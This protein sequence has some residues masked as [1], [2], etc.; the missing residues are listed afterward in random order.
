MNLLDLFVLKHLQVTELQARLLKTSSESGSQEAR[1]E[2]NLAPRPLTADSGDS[3]PAY[4]V[5]AQLTCDSGDRQSNGPRFHATVG[6]QTV[7][8]QVQGDPIDLAQ[9]SSHHATLT[10]QLYPLLQNELRVLLL[11]L[12]LEKLNLPFDLAAR[13]EAHEDGSIQLSGALH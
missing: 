3:L 11:R 1:V 6:L 10:R 13:A 8:Q 9:F 7:Y 5:G 2:M 4:Q 12:G